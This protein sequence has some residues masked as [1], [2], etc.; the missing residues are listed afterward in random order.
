MSNSFDKPRNIFL[1]LFVIITVSGVVLFILNIINPDVLNNPPE[2]TPE[3]SKEFYYINDYLKDYATYNKIT[4]NLPS[5]YITDS[6]D[7]NIL[8]PNNSFTTTS[9]RN[10][11]IGILITRKADY[12][13]KRATSSISSSYIAIREKFSTN[14]YDIN[15]LKED[16]ISTIFYK[17]YTDKPNTRVRGY[18]K[19]TWI[20]SD[21]KG[22][23]TYLFENPQYY[24]PTIDGESE[25]DILPPENHKMYPL[26]PLKAYITFFTDLE[27]VTSNN[28]YILK[29]NE[30][31]R[32][33]ETFSYSI[34]ID[35]SEF[36]KLRD[37]MV[38]ELK[39]FNTNL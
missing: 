21:E 39:D 10:S 15:T 1:D 37:K 18:F 6:Q 28:G 2:S 17:G 32:L 20:K 35:D 38:Y 4:G 19:K 25:K 36:I 11:S 26:Y 9:D 23:N 22:N 14:Y 27:T 7:M 33:G 24:I 3:S 13:V 5:M 8:F 30:E 34:T 16:Y 31:N 29:I 12:N